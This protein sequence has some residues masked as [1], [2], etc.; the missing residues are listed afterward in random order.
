[1]KLRFWFGLVLACLLAA[2]ALAS[3]TRVLS[4]SGAA[5][6]IWDNSHVYN[7]PSVAPLYYRLV[8]AELGE[9]GS[10]VHSRSS[11]GLF[12]ADEEQS[13]GV[14]GLAVNRRSAGYQA[15]L[16]YLTPVRNDTFSVDIVTR[17]QD[18][19][20]GRRLMIIAEPIAS[21]HGLYARK[22]GAYTGGILIGRSGWSALD[23]YGDEE[24][25]AGSGALDLTLGL[26]YAP[27]DNLRADAALAY[28]H[29][30]FSSSY[31]VAGQDSAQNLSSDG[32]FRLVLDGRMFYALNEDMVIVPRLKIIRTDIGYS[33][34]QGGDS[35]SAKGSTTSTNLELG[36]GWNYQY[37]SH[38][39]LVAGLDLRYSKTVIGD[40]LIVGFPGDVKHSSTVWAFPGWHLGMEANL[41]EWVTARVGATQRAVSA[42][43]VTDYADGTSR[44]TEDASQPYD[45][46]AGLTFKMGNLNLDL[47][48]NPEIIFSGGNLASGS[49]T[50][51]VASA[52]LGYRF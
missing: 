40:S 27:Q 25:K 34:T 10:L 30:S 43:E 24:R 47:L 44:Q 18:R 11:V 35:L 4:L 52:A 29:L 8:M 39:K 26:G 9:E 41:R 14:V 31:A 33:Y 1:M 17:L 32:A 42:T 50:W 21:Y 7:Y 13:F 45:F 12:Y 49:K 3:E 20:L 37:R 48:L 2:S 36:C 38:L 6:Y 19:N 16:D 5:D 51:P 46:N 28:S 23:G 15:L 22:I